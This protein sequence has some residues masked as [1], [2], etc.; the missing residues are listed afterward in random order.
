MF[1]QFG[2]ITPCRMW[3]QSTW[4]A[5]VEKILG[6]LYDCHDKGVNLLSSHI[7]ALKLNPDLRDQNKPL[8]EKIQQ[9]KLRNCIQ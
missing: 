1:V 8:G 3:Q 9:G 4:A 6:D 7:D 2:V 5:N